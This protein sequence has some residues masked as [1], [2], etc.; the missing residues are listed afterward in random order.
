M[1]TLRERDDKDLPSLRI[2]LHKSS[3]TG[4][5]PAKTATHSRS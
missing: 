5:H 1:F 2:P 4:A 3:R